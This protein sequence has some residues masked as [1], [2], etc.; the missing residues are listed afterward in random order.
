MKLF[1]RDYR[2][3]PQASRVLYA[4]YELAYTAVDFAAS[5]LFVTGSV[6]FLL[7]NGGSTPTWFYLGGSL[8]FASKPT[9]RMIR[10]IQL[11]TMGDLDHLAARQ[12]D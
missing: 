3:G 11:Y 10:E 5:A 1:Q 12:K 9:L 2:S 7:A 4:K 6:L 8:L